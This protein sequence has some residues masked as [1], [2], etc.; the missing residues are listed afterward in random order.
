VWARTGCWGVVVH[1]GFT[2]ERLPGSR[3]CAL[4]EVRSSYGEKVL[5]CFL[6][7]A[8]LTSS[9]YTSQ[10]HHALIHSSCPQ[11]ENLY[12][13][14]SHTHLF[15]APTPTN[16]DHAHVNKRSL[17][18]GPTHCF[19]PPDSSPCL[20]LT[21]KPILHIFI[22]IRKSSLNPRVLNCGGL[23]FRD[24]TFDRAPVR[25]SPHRVFSISQYEA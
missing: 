12:S 16:F 20:P 18:S 1:D 22:L 13:K 23:T 7:P 8:V 4:V 9:D 14:P 25:R 21:S 2:E 11:T 17:S 10:S 5:L 24:K 3:D 15:H 6:F 19:F